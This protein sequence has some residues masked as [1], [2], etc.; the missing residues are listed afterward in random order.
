[1]SESP[2]SGVLVGALVVIA[3]IA[4][5]WLVTSGE[6]PRPEPGP[7]DLVAPQAEP[8]RPAPVIQPAGP[9]ESE[10]LAPPD[11]RPLVEAGAPAVPPPAGD[12]VVAFGRVVFHGGPLPADV[13]IVLYDADG[14]DLDLVTAGDDGRFEIRWDE[15]LA[16]G[17]SVGTDP[18]AA[19][20]GDALIDLAPDSSGP[21]VQH[22]PGQA[23][24]ELLL[25]LGL[26]PT[27]TG[28]VYER[29]TGKP[30]AGAE[31]NAVS[32]HEAYLLNE[33]FAITEED[34]SY[35]LEL[36]DL[37]LDGLIVWTRTEGYQAQAFGPTDVAPVSA[38]GETLRV[39]FALDPPVAWRG[40]V[41]SALDGKP[42]PDAT[43]TIGNDEAAFLDW[44]DFEVSGDDGR[45]ELEMP[46]IP[47]EGTWIHVQ[48]FDYAPVAVR[49][50]RPGEEVEVRLPLPVTVTGRV[51]TRGS[52]EPVEAASVQF[53]FDGESFWG[54]NGL[55]DEDYTDA[56]GR[57]EFM[58]EYAPI[59]AALVKVDASDHAHF[60]L[61]FAAV[62]KPGG[63]GTWVVEIEMQPVE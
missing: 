27:V 2:R 60:E 53:F 32:S 26:P 23:P 5:V 37:P 38:P 40:R 6:E 8:E 50:V 58:L 15:P 36:E 34:G 14:T 44:S 22:L 43:I 10:A 49:S 20:L 31:V 42:V 47:V 55:Y 33:C 46:D 61:P 16:T 28:R 63:G 18:V 30:L 13:D 25:E 57:F 29:A 3:A 19:E 4:V 51:T 35:V 17:W 54:D 48:A 24:V 21:L 59:D 1:M 62:A 9:G 56:E 7:G 45:W 12:D 52:G 41:L 11:A 39:D